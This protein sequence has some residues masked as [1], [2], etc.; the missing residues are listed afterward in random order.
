MVGIEK[1]SS[2]GPALETVRILFREYQQELGE[3]LCF[4]SFDAELVDPLKKY[5]GEKGAVFIAYV[6][7][8]AAGCIALTTIGEGVCEMKRLYVRPAYRKFGVGRKLVKQLLEAAPAMGFG[9]MKLD[10]LRRLSPAIKLYED[11]GFEHTSA[12]YSNPLDEVVYM[13]KSLQ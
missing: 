7:Q 12:Y 3:D 9:E 4:Q 8:E 11:F 6:D 5:G 1:V 13:K 10:T 2:E